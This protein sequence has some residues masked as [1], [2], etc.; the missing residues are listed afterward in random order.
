MQCTIND[1]YYNQK[2]EHMKNFYI[3]GIDVPT[4]MVK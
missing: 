1:R 4:G 2:H 3:K